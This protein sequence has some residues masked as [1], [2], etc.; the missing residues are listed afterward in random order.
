LGHAGAGPARPGGDEVGAFFGVYSTLNIES[1][2]PFYVGTL[3]KMSAKYM[4]PYVAEFQFRYNNRSNA[5]IFGA[6]IGAC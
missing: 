3:Y 2:H 6:V 4:P 1:P 5:D